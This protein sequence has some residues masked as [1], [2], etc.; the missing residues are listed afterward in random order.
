MKRHL[1][2]LGE[3]LRMDLLGVLGQATFGTTILL[4]SSQFG[5][6]LF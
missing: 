4:L 3:S 2:N 1:D 6:F 5:L